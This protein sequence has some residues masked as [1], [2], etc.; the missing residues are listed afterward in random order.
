MHPSASSLILNKINNH[1]SVTIF[2]F[3][4]I[5]P[6]FSILFCVMSRRDGS[7]LLVFMFNKIKA[8]LLTNSISF[9]R[10][11]AQNTTFIYPIRASSLTIASPIPVL[12]PVTMQTLPTVAFPAIKSTSTNL[13][14]YQSIKFITFFQRNNF[15]MRTNFLIMNPIFGKKKV[16][17]INF[18]LGIKK[19]NHY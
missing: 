7:H 19:K 18:K 16:L 12:A 14:L 17:M 13:W 4:L 5:F 8:Y 1:S 6:S 3:P 15:I 9:A 11:L 2:H 10:R